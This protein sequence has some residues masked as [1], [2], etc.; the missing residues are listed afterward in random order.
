MSLSHSRRRFLLAGVAVGGGLLVGHGLFKPRDL[1]GSRTVLASAD[2]EFAL[3]AWL[4]NSLD[5][6]VTVAVPRAEMG[7][8]I[9]TALPMLVAEE[10]D[11]PW[12]SIAVEQAPIASVYGNIVA[13]ITALPMD[14]RDEGWLA[15]AG[16]FGLVRVARALGMQ[17]TGGSNSVRDAWLPMRAA[18]ARHAD[19]RGGRAS[20]SARRRSRGQRRRGQTWRQRPIT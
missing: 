2:G 10:L 8:G 15:S 13:L 17:M 6:R 1:L 11:V 12:T 4:R 19:P 18:S 16:R 7:Q 5:G 14:E 20:R 3:N 9:Y